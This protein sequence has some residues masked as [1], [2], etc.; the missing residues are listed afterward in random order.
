V[1]IGLPAAFVR[2]LA[3]DVAA[4]YFRNVDRTLR[5]IEVRKTG[6][7]RARMAFLGRRRIGT[8]TVAVRIDSVRGR[9]RSGVPELGFADGRVRVRLPVTLADGGGRATIRLEWDSRGLASPVCGDL[10][11]TRAVTGRVRPARYDVRGLVQLSALG[12]TIVADPD[13]PELAVRIHVEPTEAS[14]ATLDSVLALKGGACGLAVRRFDVRERVL[15]LLARG[16]TVRIPQRFFRPIRLPIA[17]RT[18]LP[19]P[20]RATPLVVEPSGLHVSDRAVWL[21]AWV[22]LGGAGQGA[23]GGAAR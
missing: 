1:L 11:V 15:A 3:R 13:F 20:G 12:G 10:G 5:G 19:I 22:R 16:F 4:E 7:V 6:D 2:A 18:S 23:P 17:V 14:L 8:Y 21:G 9:L